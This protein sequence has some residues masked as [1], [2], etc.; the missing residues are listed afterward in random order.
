MK[1]VRIPD[2]AYLISGKKD[3]YYAD[4]CQMTIG[5]NKLSCLDLYKIMTDIPQYIKLLFKLRDIITKPFGI[6]NIHGFNSK[7]INK[8]KSGDMMLKQTLLL[9]MKN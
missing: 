8:I 7:N 6:K 3:L 9:Q 2:N 1:K 5:N 4:S